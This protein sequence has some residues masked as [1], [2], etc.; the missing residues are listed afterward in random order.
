MLMRPAI[1]RPVHDKALALPVIPARVHCADE[2]KP[3][4]T[5]AG[6]GDRDDADQPPCVAVL[7][8]AGAAA[9]VAAAGVAVPASAGAAAVL[10]MAGAA[11]VAGAGASAGAMAAELAAAGAC[12]LDS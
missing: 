11:V 2:K 10:D 6:F 8:S 12:S 9:V 7:A 4:A 1:R 3:A 5:A